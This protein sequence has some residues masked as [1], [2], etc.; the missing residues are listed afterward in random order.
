MNKI[1]WQ[2]KSKAQMHSFITSNEKEGYTVTSKK[3]HQ[4]TFYVEM[5]KIDGG[6]D[7]WNL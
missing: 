2:G 3:K 1:K 5:T 4:K 7:K 6:N